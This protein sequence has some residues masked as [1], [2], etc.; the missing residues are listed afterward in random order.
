MLKRKCQALSQKLAELGV[1]ADQHRAVVDT[2]KVLDADRKCFRLVGGVLVERKV[3]DTLPELQ[4]THAGV[5]SRRALRLAAADSIQPSLSSHPTATSSLSLS[6]SS[7]TTQILNAV[8]LLKA[9]LTESED[10]L[11]TMAVRPSLE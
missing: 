2:L 5:R 7:H 10:K 4:E 1:E 3:G 11:H 9:Q 8:N 6:L